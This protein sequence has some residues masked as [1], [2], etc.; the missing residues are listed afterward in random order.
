M[1]NMARSK[2]IVVEGAQGAGITTITDYLRYKIKHTNLYRLSGV[3]DSSIDGL[4]KS[5]K[6]YYDLLVNSDMLDMPH[7]FFK[8]TFYGVRKQHINQRLRDFM[9]LDI[10]KEIEKR[11]GTKD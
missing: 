9:N 6:M 7:D 3:S 4:E 11:K 8:P 2:I 10:T 1:V 5:K